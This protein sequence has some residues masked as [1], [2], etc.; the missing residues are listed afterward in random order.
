[1]GQDQGVNLIKHTCDGIS[2]L[3]R[4]IFPVQNNSG[5]GERKTDQNS[6]LE[7]LEN[8]T[9]YDEAYSIYANA[10]EGTEIKARAVQ[11]YPRWQLHI[12]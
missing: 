5:E 9:T 12:A 10:E 1:M 3:I 8:A 4:K 6:V 7:I 11:K 2:K